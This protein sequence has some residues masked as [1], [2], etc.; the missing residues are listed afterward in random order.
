MKINQHLTISQ[1]AEYLR[2]TQL[3]LKR[4]EK[5]GI[6]IPDRVG[7]RNDRSYSKKLINQ[8]IES[9]HDGA[10]SL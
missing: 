4:W 5:Q 1:A 7:R 3:T 8:F 10:Y 6:L 9:N 2:V